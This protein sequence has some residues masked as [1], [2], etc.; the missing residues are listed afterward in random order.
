MESA[1]ARIKRWRY[2]DQTLPTSQVPFIGDFV[3]IVCAVSNKFLGPLSSSADEEADRQLGARMLELSKQSNILK[4]E[5]ECGNLERQR[6]VWVEMSEAEMEDFPRLS[7]EALRALTCGVYQIK[8]SPGYIQEHLDGNSQIHVHREQRGLIHVR[9][10]SRHIS[11][12]QYMLWLKYNTSEI[13][14][15][16]CKCRAG[17]RVVGMCAHCAAIIWYLS[18]ARHR[19]VSGIGVR[20]WCDYLAD[21]NDIPAVID[22]SDSDSDLN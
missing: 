10:Q 6:K 21:A 13:A 14:A 12:K 15:W 20:N 11:S 4:S 2:L 19:F 1:N 16:Y 17:A 22:S 9:I 18:Y 8:L 3:R 5:I 7:E